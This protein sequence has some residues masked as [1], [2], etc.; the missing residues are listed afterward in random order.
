[1]APIL[2]YWNLRGLGDPIRLLLAQ[3]DVEYELKTYNIGAAPEYSKDDFRSGANELGL[4]FPNL[5]YY[6][7]G[8]VKLSQTVAILRY[9]GRKNGLAGTEENE[10]TRCDLAE[11]ASMDMIM[12]LFKCWRTHD[13]TAQKEINEYIPPKLE[14]LNKFLGS[15]PFVLGEKVSYADCIMYSLLDFVRIY[16]CE[17]IEAHSTLKDFLSKFESLPKID[18]YLKSDKFSRLPISGPMYGWGGSAEPSETVETPV[19]FEVA[20]TQEVPE[21]TE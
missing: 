1:M 15:G 20:E 18:G 9:L 13:E 6:I 5:P 4:D 14:Q 10:V 7:D 16:K 3:A 12:F 11:Q 21:A 17:L 19:T 8:D 2:G